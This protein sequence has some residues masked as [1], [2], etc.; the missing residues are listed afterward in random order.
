MYTC[1]QQNSFEYSMM[2]FIHHFLTNMLQ[3]VFWPSSS[4]C[5]YY[6]NTIVINSIVITPQLRLYNFG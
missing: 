3:P 6:K 4:Y 5:C 2:Y 1:A